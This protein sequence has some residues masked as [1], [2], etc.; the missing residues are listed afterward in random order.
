M[1]NLTTEY[2]ELHGEENIF[3]IKNSVVL[4]DLRGKILWFLLLAVLFSS[5]NIFD[6]GKIG[7][8]DQTEA[9]YPGEAVFTEQ[10]NF[11]CGVWYSHSAGIGRLDGYRIRGWSDL[12]GA[13]KAKAQTLFPEIDTGN[14]QTYSAKS[15]PQNGDYVI[16]FDDTAYGQEE[17]DSGNNES[18]GFSYM[19]L[20]RA[21][22][23]F[24]GD[25]N[26]GAIIIEYFEGAGPAWLSDTQGLT[27]DEK[28]FFGI[29]YKVID[30]NT[31]QM[32]NP[33]DLAA[34]Y[35]KKH[36][37]TEQGT[38]VEAVGTFDVENEAEFISW[39]VVFPQDRK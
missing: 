33:V 23:I 30:N 10:L 27:P 6:Y 38:L 4:R 7:G 8:A 22:N 35:A 32:A 29:F 16:L 12:T 3:H 21:I 9:Y 39:G 25:K 20:V 2:T 24:N 28:P 14:L 17:D 26:R 15:A 37:Y 34:M 31:V 19:G 18:W 1:K 13:D 36:Y 5:C 11:L